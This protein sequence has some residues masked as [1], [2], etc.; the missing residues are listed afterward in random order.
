MKTLIAVVLAIVAL[1]SAESALGRWFS[2]WFSPPLILPLLLG[3]S[4]LLPHEALFR[5]TLLGAA[6]AELG[7]GLPPG[8]AFFATLLAPHA[9]LALNR[10]PRPE[11]SWSIRG[12]MSALAQFVVLA[13]LGMSPWWN[14]QPVFSLPLFFFRLVVPA[15]AA[16]GIAVLVQTAFHGERTKVLLR[17]L[18]VPLA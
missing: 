9:L 13:M 7:S 4:F 12:G 5:L 2:P 11:L 1:A 10:R 8:V 17:L 18:H 14:S 15:A 3:S 16:G 6:A